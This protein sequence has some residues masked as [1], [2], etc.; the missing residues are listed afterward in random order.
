MS[1]DSR[2]E[3]LSADKRALLEARLKGKAPA[4]RQ[5]EVVTRV[6]GEGPDHP[7]S[8]AQERM[9]FL[10]QFTPGNP[11]YNVPVAVLVSA[12][13]DVDV[14]ERALS[15]V[16]RRHEGLRTSFHMVDGELRQRV[17]PPFHMRVEVIDVRDRVG[18]DFGRDVDRLVAD[19][20]SRSFDLSKLPLFRVTLLRVSEGDYALVITMQH[21]V[22]DGW[23]Y[24]LVLHEVEELYNAFSAGL[25]SPL[26]EPTL[27][28]ADFSVW[29]RKFLTGATL[30]AQVAYWRG[31]LQGA[32]PLLLPTDHPRPPVFTYRGRFHRY[33]VA[34]E[35]LERLRAIC[36][37][38]GVT[39]NMV[40]MAGFYVLLQKYSG[41]DDVVVGTLLGNRSRA[42]LEQLVGVFVN[43]A[44]MRMDLSGDP[45]FRTL[46]RAA[47]T[48]VL[49]ADRHQDLPFERLIDLLG[50]ERDLSRHPVFQALYF[51][52]TFVRT[53]TGPASMEGEGTWNGLNSRPITPDHD[54]S[55]ID[56][57][58]SKFDLMM[59]TMEVDEELAV[60]MEYCTDLF[61]HDTIR[62]MGDHFALLLDRA[63][64]DVDQPISRISI[65]DDAERRAL[66]AWG[67]GPALPG[68]RTAVHRAF[69][70]R[71]KE[72]PET[73][74]VVAGDE[75]L[76]YAEVDAW[77]NAVAREL[78]ERGAAPGAIVGVHLERDASLVPALLGILKVG[79]AYLPLDPAYPP[80]RLG[81]M[82]ED[83][84]AALV[85]SSPALRDQL[86]ASA[87][88]V[89]DVPARP[90]GA[91]DAPSVEVATSDLA[92]LI[93][94]SGSTGKPKAVQVE[95]GTASAFLTAFAAEPGIRA[96]D[97]VLGVTTISFDISV[98]E[99]F[100]PLLNGARVVI[101]PRE[102]AVDAGAL[103]AVVEREG[104]TLMQATPSTWR[105]LLNGGWSGRPGLRI[106]TGAEALTR[107]LAAELLARAD[108]VWNVYGPTETTVWAT[109]HR[110]TDAAEG[111]GVL[112]IGRPIAGTRLYVLDPAGQPVPAGVAGE[113]W[114][115]G[116]GVARGYRNRPEL[117]AERFVRDPF[118]TA[119]GARMYGTG[120][121]VRWRPDGTLAFLGRLDDPVK[122]RGHR[123]ELGEVEAA[124]AAHPAVRQAAVALREDV[125]GQRRLVAYVL[126]DIDAANLT[127][128]LRAWLRERLP[129]YMVPSAFVA[130]DAI[131]LTPSGK[132]NRR[133]LPAPERE[134]AV[135]AA[136]YEAPRNAEEEALARIWAEVLRRERVGVHDNF[137]EL[138]GDS[139]LSIQ[140]V[141]RAASE[142]GLRL[143][144]W[145]MFQHQ[146]VAEQVAAAE[147]V[148]AE[149]MVA[150]SASAEVEPD[151]PDLDADAMDAVMAQ[152]GF[153]ED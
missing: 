68:E 119:E 61:E 3:G 97:V 11:M 122:L 82:L 151:F 91:V 13:V 24:P 74:A 120:D 49:E 7:A 112:P 58:V 17:N 29:Q 153:D 76:T 146:T 83:S 12:A 105:L 78:A 99:I 72:A 19:E 73:V 102:Q 89:L 55:L 43:T 52:H 81:Y 129:E 85:L 107:D 64:R 16:V 145:Q 56:T 8:F 114:I 139:I 92:Y 124:V 62:R 63:A 70:A 39:L 103:A 77:A 71:A 44:A 47:K 95:H 54:A 87:A 96:D 42:E 4:F 126:G 9:W 108:E 34:R 46:V 116:A 14:L 32:P 115:G 88:D 18:A 33:R 110:V 59:A 2:R 84:G 31:K 147:R 69:E 149:D 100:L 25:P 27:R 127:A 10:T 20:G 140:V 37:E 36:R 60:V 111:E 125:P 101:V 138:G 15:E 79:A 130:I 57:G 109:V 128:E 65:L 123:I 144:P 135:R 38:E 6:A 90:I 131:P 104:V 150:A 142:A 51:H 133:A 132:V 41:Q 45:A 148:T 121:R 67:T 21:I 136:V 98:L 106:L 66:D 113:L 143:H 5:R 23:A 30:E 117:N 94:T 137:F 35:T 48:A 93:Y 134:E 26:P 75:R 40:L 22:I 118:S 1:S 152:L 50:V 141:S 53:H 28:Y 80:E 86:P